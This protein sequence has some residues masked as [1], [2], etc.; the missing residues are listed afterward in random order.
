MPMRFAFRLPWFLTL[1]FRADPPTESAPAMGHAPTR[2]FLDQVPPIM[3]ADREYFV[4]RM[5]YEYATRATSLS[6]G[7]LSRLGWEMMCCD[8]HD[9]D[10]KHWIFESIINRG[11][12]GWLKKRNFLVAGLQ[13]WAPVD[14]QNVWRMPETRRE[15]WSFFTEHMHKMGHHHHRSDTQLLLWLAIERGLSFGFIEAMLVEAFGQPRR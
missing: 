15:A 14:S 12:H 8:L 6:V 1:A 13:D 5:Q 7:H 4:S 2:A 3:R 11:V 10:W 9:L